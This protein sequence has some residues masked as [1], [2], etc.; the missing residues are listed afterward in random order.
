MYGDSAELTDGFWSL[1]SYYL[2]FPLVPGY[3]YA[4]LFG[5]LLSLAIYQRY[6]EEGDLFVE[7][8][9]GLLRAGGVGSRR[10]S[11]CSVSAST[12]TNRGSGTAASTR[13]THPSPRPRPRGN[14]LGADRG[15]SVMSA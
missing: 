8:I 6:V 1:W 11:W 10:R 14:R 7:P 5:S 4:Y 12:S 3:M 2:H 15:D 13:S 9:L